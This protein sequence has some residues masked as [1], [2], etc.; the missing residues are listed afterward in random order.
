MLKFSE[1]FFLCTGAAFQDLFSDL[2]EAAR[3]G[4]FI[5]VRAAGPTG[6]L[7]CDGYCLDTGEL[8]QVYAPRNVETTL[9]DMVAKTKADFAGALAHWRDKLKKWV[10]VHNDV[11]GQRAERV[12]ALAELA[13]AHPTIEF[14]HWSKSELEGLVL[15][16]DSVGR[17][18]L[19]GRAPEPKD[20]ASPS[21]MVLAPLLK[22]IEA[23]P[24]SA[25][26]DKPIAEVP[27]NKLEF[28]SLSHHVAAFVQAG[29][30]GDKVVEMFIAQRPDPTY[31]QTL[32]SAFADRYR[33]L[34][35]E[36]NGPDDIFHGL[37]VFVGGDY[38][39]SAAHQAA[40]YCV[41]AYFFDRCDIFETP[42]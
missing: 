41:L 18:K 35:D 29:R 16:L 6:D 36:G 19:F 5:R 11:D 12:Q 24:Q 14:A 30:R 20:F 40:I 4:K 9:A 42:S 37:T 26:S 15:G 23:S 21:F 25:F 13:A 1:R 27:P 34:R 33:V 39:R 28:N 7:K 32:A 2:M 3:P 8:F 22:H 17:T 31:G 10:F 38:Q